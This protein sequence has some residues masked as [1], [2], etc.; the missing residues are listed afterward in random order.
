[1]RRLLATLAIGM[2][3]AAGVATPAAAG[4]LTSVP[5]TNLQTRLKVV[6]PRV[7]GLSIAVIELGN[8]LELRNA[9]GSEVVVLGYDDEPYLRVGPEGVFTNRRSP[10]TYLNADR[11]ATRAVP[12]DAVA[13][14]PP[15][16]ERISAGPVARWYDHRVHWMGVQ[17]PP[18]ARAAPDRR[19]VVF[20]SW[21][22][23]ILRGDAR[24]E[25]RGDLVW[26]PGPGVWPWLL[27]AL[28]PLGLGTLLV[29]G[30]LFYRVE[31]WR[32]GLLAGGA[33]LVLVAAAALLAGPRHRSPALVLSAGAACVVAVLAVALLPR[34]RRA[35]FYA[36]AAAGTLV[37]GLSLLALPDLT[38]SQLPWHLSPAA[39][40]AVTALSLGVGATLAAVSSLAAR[41][42]ATPRA[43]GQAPG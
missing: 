3:G 29:G 43:A 11:R 15:E 24:V 35:G 28:A 7:E 37:A 23:P 33:L 27:L 30:A 1:M 10:A 22:V 41:A 5:A 9:T 26:V 4:A 39:A 17:D 14:A 18:A 6:E 19:H 25:A 8:R 21:T 32:T 13:H 20:P 40:R 42:P 2:L 38:R 36:A 31:S 16:W 34:R 12:D